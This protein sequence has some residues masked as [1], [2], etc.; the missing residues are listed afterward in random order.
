MQRNDSQIQ[1]LL[2]QIVEGQKRL[3]DRQGRLEEGQKE[4]QTDVRELKSDV[5][6]LKD[7][8]NGL[9][10]GQNELKAG[11]AELK[12]GQ[13]IITIKLGGQAEQLKID[14]SGIVDSILGL[15][16]IIDRRVTRLEKNAGL[17]SLE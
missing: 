4:I 16:D 8:V 12:K 5:N 9:K 13:R 1:E 10:A 17:P 14:H 6:G 11:Q 7:D 15:N 2:L 3:E